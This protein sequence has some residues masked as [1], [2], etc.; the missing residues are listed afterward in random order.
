MPVDASV[1]GTSAPNI[2][3]PTYF[4]GVDLRA[5]GVRNQCRRALT[6]VEVS[7]NPVEEIVGA[8][9][10]CS[11]A[12]AKNLLLGRSEVLKAASSPGVS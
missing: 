2:L 5:K 11:T 4:G 9:F 8:S 7:L 6:L 12:A 3:T 1:A 10:A